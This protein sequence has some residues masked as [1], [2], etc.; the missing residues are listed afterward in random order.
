MTYTEQI[1]DKPP[2]VPPLLSQRALY[3]ALDVI[4]RSSRCL[5]PG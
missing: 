3:T 5:A 2:I 4:R 1:A